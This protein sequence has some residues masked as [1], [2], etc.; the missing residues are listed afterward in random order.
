MKF[1]AER[2]SKRSTIEL[3]GPIEKVFPLFGPVLEKEW[4]MGWDP[5]IIYSTSCLVEEHMIFRTQSNNTMEEYF[6]WTVTQYDPENIV[7]SILY[8][9]FIGYGL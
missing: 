9:L 5:E 3:N 8:L 6:T 1:K 2:I 7:L 4:A